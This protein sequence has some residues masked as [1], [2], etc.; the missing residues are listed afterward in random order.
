[1]ASARLKPRT[2]IAHVREGTK[3]RSYRLQSTHKCSVERGGGLP[4]SDR[5]ALSRSP[6]AMARGLGRNSR[7]RWRLTHGPGLIRSGRYCFPDAR[8]IG[9]VRE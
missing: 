7:D 5:R 3:Q 2:N 1:M 4:D 8:E 9:N 6:E